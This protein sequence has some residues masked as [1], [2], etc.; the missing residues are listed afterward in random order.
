MDVDFEIQIRSNVQNYITLIVL[1]EWSNNVALSSNKTDLAS[2]K[3]AIVDKWIKNWWNLHC[4]V[5]L[6][7]DNSCMPT[8]PLL[9]CPGLP[10]YSSIMSLSLTMPF[11]S[12]IAVHVAFQ[13]PNRCLIT[14]INPGR[15]PSVLPSPENQT[16]S[17][18]K[19]IDSPLTPG[20]VVEGAHNNWTGTSV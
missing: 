14:I 12:F 9:Q 13:V 1:H 19:C 11:P 4:Q 10:D 15:L 16:P 18:G 7:H 17:S 2:W 8:I 3:M 5:C 6:L 20:F